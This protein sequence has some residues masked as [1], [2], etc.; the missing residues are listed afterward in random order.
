MTLALILLAI[1][2]LN[3]TYLLV[4]QYKRSTRAESIANI[5]ADNMKSISDLLKTSK[6]TLSDPKLQQAFAADD[7]V[8][9]FFK[10]LI[11]VQKILDNFIVDNGEKKEDRNE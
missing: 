11:A 2:A 3:V 7:E 10:N 9:I 1:Y 8:G 4:I 5:L 6:K